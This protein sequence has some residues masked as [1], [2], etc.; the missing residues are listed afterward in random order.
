VYGVGCDAFNPQ[1]VRNLYEIKGRSFDKPLQVL[2]CVPEQVEMF[3]REIPQSASE[4]M[5]RYWP[6]PLTLVF[7]KKPEIS[8][9]LT[10]SRGTIG[11]RMPDS[12]STLELIMLSG[13]LA[14]T[15]ANISGGEDPKTAEEVEAQL[16]ENVDLILDG[17]RTEVGLASTVV[18]ITQNPPKV[19]REG[20]LR[21]I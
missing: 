3:A 10:A 13:P 8:D 2:I 9:I 1:A 12:I 5:E 7:R 18:D 14:A 6:G 17:G 16:G 20:P 21:I 15:S 4:L 11:L 19:L